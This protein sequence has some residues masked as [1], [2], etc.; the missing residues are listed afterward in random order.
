[1]DKKEDP[2]VKV[3]MPSPEILT[4][5]KGQVALVTGANTGI[6]K[7]VAISLAQAGAHVA[8]N[9]YA[10]D[11]E[12]EQVVEEI[13]KY[14]VDSYAYKADVSKEQDVI[15]MFAD[16]KKKWGT[17]DILVNNAGI[18][19]DAPIDT[20]TLD[21]WNAVIHTNLT[22]QFLCSREAIKEFKRRG[23]VQNISCAAGKILCM[24]S[25]HQMIPWAG[26]VNYAASKGGIHLLMMSL[27]QEVARFRIR[28]N[29]IAPG[30]IRTHIN[31]GAWDTKEALDSLMHLIPYKRIGEP[32]DIGRC[33]AWLVS[34]HADYL[35]GTTIFVDGGMTL[36]PGFTTGG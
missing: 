21:D 2:L 27:A 12:A 11:S 19:K 17:I 20:M 13:K 23:V 35:T 28:V 22:S 7:A 16:I 29:A 6:G 30:A 36:F 9:Y 8:I 1:M 10:G 24:S 5:L 3:V 31:Q 25:V 32:E 4:L 14:G 33:A 34:D 18:Q 26:H 15:A